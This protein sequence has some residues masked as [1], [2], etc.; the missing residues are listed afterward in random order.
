MCTVAKIIKWVIS[1]VK[2]K[3]I[4]ADLSYLTISAKVNWTLKKF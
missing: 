2:K 1:L 3:V 4:F